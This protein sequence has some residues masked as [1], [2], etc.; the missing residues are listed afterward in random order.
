MTQPV[1]FADAS[2]T[3]WGGA[4]VANLVT[5]R[6]MVDLYSLQH[7]NKILTYGEVADW[8]FLL[9][10]T[11]NAGRPN[12]PAGT[13]TVF[14]PYLKE[15]PVNAL[16][17]HSRLCEVGK[18][19][20]DA[21]W[22]WDARGHDP[23]ILIALPDRSEPIADYLV[24]CNVAVKCPEIPAQRPAN[25]GRAQ[26]V[27]FTAQYPEVLKSLNAN[28]RLR[29]AQA[30]FVLA[31]RQPGAFPVTLKQMHDWRILLGTPGQGPVTPGQPIRPSLPH[32]LGNPLRNDATKVVAAGTA[33]DDPDA[34][35]TYSPETGELRVVVSAD[36]A[37][38]R[39][40]LE[41][42][43][44]RVPAEKSAPAPGQSFP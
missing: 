33:K 10:R 1:P 19:T 30:H 44:E 5:L 6:S 8:V 37:P 7:G 42:N 9:Q 22:I 14:G 40:L 2:M 29:I 25:A 15:V 27:G 28:L 34:G 16:T 38:T 12:P 11:D 21:G 3:T 31:L 26:A 4:T 35:W 39:G 13:K 17:G 36:V 20:T 43:I 32:P 24:A 41:A 23:L 18:V